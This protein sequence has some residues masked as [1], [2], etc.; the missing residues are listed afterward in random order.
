MRE[1]NR[2]NTEYF[3]HSLSETISFQ[4]SGGK[5]ASLFFMTSDNKY[6]IKEISKTEFKMFYSFCNDYLTFLQENYNQNRKSLLCLIFAMFKIRRKRFIVMENCQYFVPN[7]RNEI[8]K[9]DLKGSTL[10]RFN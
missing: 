2:I 1:I 9:Y 4:P 6:V 10:N 5:T 3:Y 8:I 7:T